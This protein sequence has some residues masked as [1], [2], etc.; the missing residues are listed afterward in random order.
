MNFPF[1]HVPIGTTY[2][3][4]HYIVLNKVIPSS[5]TVIN[6]IM[7]LLITL[8]HGSNPLVRIREPHYSVLRGL[9]P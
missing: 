9:S 6:S 1:S 4:L 8:R 2:I 3:L 7:Q 5:K